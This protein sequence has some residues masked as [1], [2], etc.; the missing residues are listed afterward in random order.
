MTI[1][2]SNDEQQQAVSGP[3]AE[4]FIKACALPNEHEARF[5]RA[6]GEMYRLTCREREV[7]DRIGIGMTNRLIARELG[8]V[9]RTVKS[10]VTQIMIKLGIEGRAEATIL[11]LSM[12]FASHQSAPT[13]VQ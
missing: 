6:L 9:E 12:R 3:H 8:V 11:S 4:F 7:F 10:H 5:V 2:V 13:K 1:F